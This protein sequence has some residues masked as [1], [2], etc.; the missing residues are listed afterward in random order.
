MI[1]KGEKM[2]V[3]QRAS[4][5][6]R[7]VDGKKFYV[8]GGRVGGKSV[9]NKFLGDFLTFPVWVPISIVNNF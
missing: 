8:K 6:Y 3:R 5:F 4:I 9:P 7:F 2:P 1:S